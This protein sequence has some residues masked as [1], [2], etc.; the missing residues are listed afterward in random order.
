MQLSL[1]T[2]GFTITGIFFVIYAYTFYSLAGKKIQTIL[3]SFSYAYFALAIAFL[4]WGVA[5]FIGEQ[6]LLN[7]SVIGG[8]VLFLLSTIFLLDLYLSD[9]KN[10]RTAGLIGVSLLAIV[11]LWW[12]IS[13]F[14]P[15]PILSDG[16]LIFN[17][18]FPVAVIL[19][20][21]ILLIWLPINIK[22]A[23]LVSQ[24]IKAEGI[25]FI[26]SSIYVMTTIAAL[27]FISARTVP[28]IILSFTAI[29]ICFAMLIF[30]NIVI[31][32]LVK[33]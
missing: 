9:N 13:Y 3:K 15:R 18:D 25:S 33:G 22:V 23:K 8:N 29:T 10:F 4:S 6:N 5:A 20:L 2:I 19:S 11:F 27:L 30:S 24:K 7:L 32:K 14:P 12:R 28:I 31:Y 1:A 16:I 17:T 21:I 26:Y